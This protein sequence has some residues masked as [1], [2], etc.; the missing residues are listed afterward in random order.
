MIRRFRLLGL[1]ALLGLLVTGMSSPAQAQKGGS[2]GGGGTS[3]GGG[4]HGGRYNILWDAAQPI[5]GQTPRAVGAINI[6]TYVTTV[7]L[8]VRLSSVNL[9]D[10]TELTVTVNAKDYYTGLPWLSRNAGTI[11]LNRQSGSLTVASL[12]VT[13]PGFLPIITT[14]VV[15]KADGTVV[16]TGHP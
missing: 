4:R 1:V 6:S 14:V 16:I 2:G 12:W 11:T 3:G 7:N 10:N 9:P 8:D 5:N 13:A 15:T